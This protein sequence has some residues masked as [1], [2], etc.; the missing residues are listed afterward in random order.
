MYFATTLTSS[1]VTLELSKRGVTPVILQLIIL[2]PS[3]FHPKSSE[4]IILFFIVRLVQ[5]LQAL[6]LFILQSVI[7]ILSQY[8]IEALELASK[9]VLYNVI[10]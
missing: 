3:H 5:F 10:L 1:K 9:I 7:S 2:T 4:L 6:T 8:H